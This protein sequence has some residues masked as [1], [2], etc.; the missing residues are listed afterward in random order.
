MVGAVILKLAL[1]GAMDELNN[2]LKDKIIANCAD[3]AVVNYP[4]KFSMSGARKGEAAIEEFF[5]K[6]FDQFTQEH[7]VA[8]D[9]SVLSLCSTATGSASTTEPVVRTSV[10]RISSGPERPRS[11]W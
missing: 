2:R 7:C 8:Q 1:R 6:C 3:C 9:C 5:D 11:H 10:G 4:G